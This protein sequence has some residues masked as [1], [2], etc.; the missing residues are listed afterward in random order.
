MRSP[1]LRGTFFADRAAYTLLE[2]MLALGLIVVAT[3]LVGSLISLYARSFTNK[4]ESIKQK[5][6]AR[7]LLTMI[8]D[9]IRAVVQTQQYDKSALE[10]MLGSGGGGSTTGGSGGAGSTGGTGSSGAGTGS[11]A[12]S[13]SATQPSMGQGFTFGNSA[14]STGASQTTDDSTQ[15]VTSYPPG[16]YGSRYQLMVDVSRIPR[17]NE[18]NVTQSAIGS[19]NDVPGDVKT[20]SYLLQSAGAFGVQDSM[21]QITS[22]P[23]SSNGGL[24]RR[25]IDRNVMKYAEENGS[26]SQLN[27]SG[28]LVAPEAVALEFS[29]FDG[30]QW[31]Y[32]WDSSQQ[33]LPWLIQVTLALQSP[34]AAETSPIEGGINLATLTLDSKKSYGIEIFQLTVA[35][36]G[37]NLQAAPSTQST[38]SGMQA[39]GL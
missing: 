25:A 8:A 24:I 21:L 33:G 36:P 29:Y 2:L 32:D 16:I 7:S 28:S 18:Y 30:S 11:G 26:T 14:G 31:V 35:I 12:A 37:A 22:T 9:D 4:G 17:T 13:A 10:Q 5:Q 19:L 34:E 23:S 3:A 38:D 20:V 1:R 27:N 39:V 6:L 15:T